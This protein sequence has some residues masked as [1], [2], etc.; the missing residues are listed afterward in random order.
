MLVGL[1][2]VLFGLRVV[3]VL[4]L[5]GYQYRSAKRWPLSPDYLPA[6]AVIVPAYNETVGIERAVRSLDASDYPDFEVVVVDDG[7]TDD[8]ADI[9]EGLA[10]D[11]VRLVRKPNGVRRRP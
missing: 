1:V 6:V 3:L 2:G 8:T 9:V 10:L 5:A 11:R 4:G 7:S